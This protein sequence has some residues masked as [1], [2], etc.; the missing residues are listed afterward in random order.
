[1]VR[2][3]TGLR[4]AKP[5]GVLRPGEAE[6]RFRLA[7]Y[8]PSEGLDPFVEHYWT[9]GWNLLACTDRHASGRH[10]SKNLRRA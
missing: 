1:M 6:K 3:M 4:T 7:R 9:V 8:L 5:T 2:A 10:K